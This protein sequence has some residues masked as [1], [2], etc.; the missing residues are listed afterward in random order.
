MAATT[1][2][3]RNG[4]VLL[5]YES[6][7]DLTSGEPLLL[8]MGLD[9][10]MVWWAD[11][12]CHQ[13]VEAGFAVV[14]FDNRDTGLSSHFESPTRQHP[15]RALLGGTVPVYTG[16]DMLD[17]IEAVLGA[18]GWPSAHVLGCSMGAGLAQALALARPSRVRSLVSAM[19]LPVTAGPVRTLT[20]LRLG[21]FVRLAG[22]GRTASREGPV[23]FL[24]ALY[25]ALSSPSHPFPEQWARAAATI[26][27]D[28]SP[29]DPRS[30]QRQ[31]ATA[32][33]FRLP[34]L[35]TVQVPTLVLA[36]GSDPLIKAAASRD[37]ARQVPG[38]VLHT[39]AGAGHTLPP[40]VWPDVVRQVRD[41][42]ARAP[43]QP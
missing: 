1:R 26:S 39:Y 5:A 29:R 13:L 23:E 11:A 27:H 16:D 9:F 25:R 35:S 17:D 32:R 20:Y 10:Q 41:L 7:G 18:V 33:T 19:G 38:A 30:A 43:A 3:A 21:T 34:P 40:E 8:I 4:E 15:F 6:F 36:G 22:L 14:R 37:I 2:Y 28:R 42:A 24:V 31:T 12:F